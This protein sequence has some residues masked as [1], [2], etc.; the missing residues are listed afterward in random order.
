MGTLWLS[1]AEGLICLKF[2]PGFCSFYFAQVYSTI[3]PDFGRVKLGVLLA[4][5]KYYPLFRSS[6]SQAMGHRKGPEPQIAW[7]ALVWEL[8]L[9]AGSTEVERLR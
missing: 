4:V 2:Y 9:K 5:P 1:G 8:G 7:E 6:G 3:L